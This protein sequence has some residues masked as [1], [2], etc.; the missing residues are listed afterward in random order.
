[1][2]TKQLVQDSN[3]NQDISEYVQTSPEEVEIPK[4][5]LALQPDFYKIPRRFGSIPVDE[6]PKGCDRDKQYYGL[7]P[8]ISLPSQRQVRTIL[9][10]MKARFV[11]A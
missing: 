5:Q 1:M 7:Y 3:P 4:V 2:R 10:P 11:F 8:R 6:L 9:W